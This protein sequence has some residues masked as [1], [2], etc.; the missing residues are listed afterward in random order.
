ML[1]SRQT[2]YAILLTSISRSRKNKIEK[3]LPLSEIF[4][5]IKPFSRHFSALFLIYFYIIKMPSDVKKL[6]LK[7]KD[8]AN[9][10]HC[11]NKNAGSF[12]KKKY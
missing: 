3:S 7:L 10:Y 12:K 4:I 1:Y 11:K 6:K 5:K 8:K 9:Y 2:S